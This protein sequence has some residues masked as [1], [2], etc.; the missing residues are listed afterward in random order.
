MFIK[1]LNK[2]RQ[3]FNAAGQILIVLNGQILKT[4]N[5]A[6]WSHCL[7]VCIVITMVVD[8]DWECL[9]AKCYLILGLR[10]YDTSA[11]MTSVQ[12]QKN[13]VSRVP[14]SGLCSETSKGQLKL[15]SILF[16][17]HH[18]SAF[19]AFNVARSKGTKSKLKSTYLR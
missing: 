8:A 4:N 6:I 13:Q 19:T 5:L 9:C 15:A 16:L 18:F 3:I 2:I 17:I 14:V 7:R 12:K 10:C 1:I 11:K